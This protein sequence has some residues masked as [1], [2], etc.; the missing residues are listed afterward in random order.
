MPRPVVCPHCSEELDI[1]LEFRGRPVRCAVCQTVFTPPADGAA[2][3]V[4]APPSLPAPGTW[5]EHRPSRR[6][7]RDDDR[8][9]RRP[10]RDDDDFGDRY[11]D[12]DRDDDRD[13]W[14]DRPRRR[15]RGSNTWVWLLVLGVFGLCVLPCGGLI[16]FGIALDHPSFQPYDS[17]K[18][19]FTAEFPGKPAETQQAAE[20]GGIRHAVE[21][22]RSLPEET[23]FVHYLDLPAQPT[24]DKAIDKVLQDACDRT[25]RILPGSSEESRSPTTADGYPAMDLHVEHPGGTSTFVRF[26][27]AGRRLY[28]VGITGAGLAAES[29]R[30][31]H[32]QAAFKIK[33]LAA[34]K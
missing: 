15:K 5:D 31:Q 4:P 33:P 16:V 1:P 23:Y 30:L 3:P 12:L 22:R 21:Y 25:V 29:Q 9:S 27:L 20:T 32:F 34:E 17:A 18:G 14:D 24:G 28:S 19:R 11:R 2:P 8:P 7:V 26:V 10:A 13:R 6:P